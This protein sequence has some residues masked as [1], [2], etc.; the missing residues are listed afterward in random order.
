MTSL[1]AGAGSFPLAGPNS[2]LSQPFCKQAAAGSPPGVMELG[3]LLLS[4]DLPIIITAGSGLGVTSSLEKEIFL[5][6]L[7]PK[8]GHLWG[9]IQQLRNNTEQ[10]HPAVMDRK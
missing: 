4:L 2:L 8:H 6:P 10:H 3:Q 9:E 7:L 5:A 1:L